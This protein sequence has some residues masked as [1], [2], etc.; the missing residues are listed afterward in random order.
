MKIKK[1]GLYQ[2]RNVIK[3]FDRYWASAMNRD[4][5]FTADDY[6]HRCA[7]AW[8]HIELL[9]KDEISVKHYLE[10]TA[11]HSQNLPS[12]HVFYL[13]NADE[14]NA[15][16]IYMVGYDEEDDAPGGFL[17]ETLAAV[18][19]A[20]KLRAFEVADGEPSVDITYGILVC[21]EGAFIVTLHVHSQTPTTR[22]GALLRSFRSH[23]A[24]QALDLYKQWSETTLKRF[25]AFLVENTPEVNLTEPEEE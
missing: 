25:L 13:R 3:K 20:N 21:T 1:L 11:R 8:E 14:L 9:L 5:P 12:P 18:S 19:G 6:T 24:G 10:L 23:Q 15:C 7:E 4:K 17:K 16:L 22:L 2:Y